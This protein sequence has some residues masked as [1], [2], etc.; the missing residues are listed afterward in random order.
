MTKKI[1]HEYKLPK[2]LTLALY[3]IAIALTLNLAKPFM[4]VNPAFAAFDRAD[5]KMIRDGIDS[6]VAAI[7]SCNS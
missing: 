6:I 7:Y 3:V 5:Y 1:I 2:A 4:S